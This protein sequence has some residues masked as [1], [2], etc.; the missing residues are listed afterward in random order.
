MGKNIYLYVLTMALLTFFVG[1]TIVKEDGKTQPPIYQESGESAV[2]NDP[3]I[4]GDSTESGGEA[5]SYEPADPLEVQLASYTAHVKSGAYQQAIEVYN[6]YLVGNMN[7]EAAAE[8]V[9]TERLNAL[10]KSAWDGSV[11][12]E[13]G[14]VALKTV[15]MISE[16]TGMAEEEVSSATETLNTAYTSKE[17]FAT[18]ET[19]KG[20]SNWKDALTYYWAVNEQD[21]NYAAAKEGVMTCTEKYRYEEFAKA[22]SQAKG[23][24]YVTAIRTLKDVLAIFPEDSLAISKISVYEKTH[25]QKVLDDASAAFVVPAED[26]ADALQIVNTGLQYYP[27]DVKLNEMKIYYASY[28]PKNLVD[29][30]VLGENGYL[31]RD[32]SDYDVYGNLHCNVLYSGSGGYEIFELKGNFNTLTATIYGM[33]ALQYEGYTGQIVIRDYS[34]GEENNIVLYRNDS[35]DVTQEPYTVELDVTGITRLYLWVDSEYSGHNIGFA[36]CILQKTAK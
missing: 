18:A 35:V 26:Y 9:L 4:Y 27:E 16:Q 29:L 36:D 17:S 34:Q 10:E 5:E 12:R 15:A 7:M 22:E 13:E 33:E 3:P 32:D 31:K 25:I 2:Q 6:M 14:T 11:G 8:R 23:E 24:D 1:C 28:E 19:L 21:S 20:L 30:R